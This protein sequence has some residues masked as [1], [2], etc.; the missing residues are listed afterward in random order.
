MSEIIE[1]YLI[2]VIGLILNLIFLPFFIPIFNLSWLR[3]NSNS[4][5]EK[6]YSDIES[7]KQNYE[8]ISKL[9]FSSNYSELVQLQYSQKGKIEGFFENKIRNITLFFYNN[10]L[11]IFIQFELK[12]SKDIQVSGL[13]QTIS[14]YVVEISNDSKFIQFY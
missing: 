2:I 7:L 12:I 1:K 14:R 9:S 11:S 6:I 8:K 3:V 4:D 10:N 13:N 5:L